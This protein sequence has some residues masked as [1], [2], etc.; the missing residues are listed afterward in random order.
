[1]SKVTIEIK[2]NP[3]NEWLLSVGGDESVSAN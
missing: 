1:M 2:C 3:I